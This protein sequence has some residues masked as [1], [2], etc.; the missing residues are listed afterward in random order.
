MSHGP[1]TINNRT[2]RQLLADK[3]MQKDITRT[4]RVHGLMRNDITKTSRANVL[5]SIRLNT[6]MVHVLVS[7]ILWSCLDCFDDQILSQLFSK[8]CGRLIIIQRTHSIQD[9][10]KRLK[11]SFCEVSR[12]GTQKWGPVPF[13]IL[14]EQV[15][16]A[17]HTPFMPCG[18]EWVQDILK[19][20][21]CA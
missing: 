6:A 18:P 11:C 7:M 10:Q 13:S 19:I 17:R 20:S 16:L 2:I 21:V 14:G 1:S 9:F 5:C 3:L 15:W 12:W 8:I 4:S